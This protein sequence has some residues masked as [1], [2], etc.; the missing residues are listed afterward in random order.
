MSVE[1]PSTHANGKTDLT[2]QA[3]PAAAAPSPMAGFRGG[4]ETGFGHMEL[5]QLW[6]LCG[7]L[8]GTGF[9]PK[10][11]TTP[12][13]A[14]AIVLAGRELGLEVM[15][16]LRGIHV[17]EGRV[18][19]SAETQLALML[20]AGMKFRWLESTD[21]QAKLEA[22][23]SG[24]DPVVVTWTIDQATRAGLAHKD[25]WKKH[26][27]AML[28]ARCITAAARM[29]AADILGNVFDLDEA[30]EVPVD[31]VV[32]SRSPA[33]Q[34]AAPAAEEAPPATKTESAKRKARQALS[35][36][37]PKEQV[38]VPAPKEPTPEEQALIAQQEG[39]SREPGEEG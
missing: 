25:N 30:R 33:P 20:R 1:S 22:L 15:Q 38:Q 24:M 37:Q 2:K 26:P 21:K 12:G 39:A 29:I 28:R 34:A 14:M 31:E 10:A 5:S 35:P 8:V 4:V 32:I 11:V 27:E 18:A 9:M 6:W 23:R 13:Q 3:P 19:L 17:I 7:Q 16:S 36:A